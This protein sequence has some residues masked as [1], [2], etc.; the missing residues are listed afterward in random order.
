MAV[1]F[2]KSIVQ[3]DGKPMLVLRPKDPRL[4]LSLA[5]IAVQKQSQ[6]LLDE[7]PEIVSNASGDYTFHGLPGQG[8]E[9]DLDRRRERQAPRRRRG[10]RQL[11]HRRG[12]GVV[13]H[14]RAAR[15]STPE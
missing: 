6:Q 14:A 8:Q 13:K 15:Q 1:K 12:A 11:R 7:L 2:H 9:A 4:A 5:E 3:V 10:W